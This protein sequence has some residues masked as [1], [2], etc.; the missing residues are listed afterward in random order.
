MNGVGKWISGVSL[1]AVL[2]A[3]A[4]DTSGLF[5]PD[6]FILPVAPEMP[7][8]VDILATNPSFDPDTGIV[9]YDGAFSLKADNG[10]GLK[11]NSA[12]YNS[13]TKAFTIKGNVRL[14][15][16]EGAK[17]EAQRV[18][19]DATTGLAKLNGAV[20][21]TQPARDGSYGIQLFS[22]RATLNT[23]EKTVRLTGDVSIYSGSTLH[24]GDSAFYD[25]SSR[26]FKTKNLRSGLD[27]IF[28]EAGAFESE[29]IDGRQVYVGENAGLTTHDRKD[30]NFWI[31]SN[32]T[33]VFPGEKVIFKN[34]KVYAGETPVF[35]LP[36]LSQ[37]LDKDLGYLFIPGARSNWG[38][39]LLNRYGIMLG[40][41]RDAVTG[42]NKDAWLLAQFHFDILSRRGIGL[43]VDLRDTRR[44][45]NEN[46]TGF[47][48]YYLNDSDPSQRRAGERRRNVNE[49]RYKIQ[50]RDKIRVAQML[51]SSRDISVDAF[52]NVTILSDEFYLE[53]FEPRTFRTD[54]EPDN[55]IG[56]SA[57]N[58]SSQLSLHARIQPNDFY[59]T[60]TRLPEITFDQVRRPIFEKRFGGGWLHE[61]HT[62]LGIFEEDLTG[63]RDGR[64]REE[65]ESLLLSRPGSPR[66]GEIDSLLNA[67]GFTRFHT[68][69]ELSRPFKIGKHLNIVPRAGIGYTAYTS[70]DGP[71]SSSDRTHLYAG[72]EAS[73]KFSKRYA[74]VSN[75]KLGLD[76]LLHIIQPYANAS[77]LRSDSLSPLF[78]GVD[79]LTPSTRP[80][81]RSPGRF[82]AIDDLEDWGV[83]RLGIRNRLLTSRDGGSHNWLSLDTYIDTFSQD[84]EFGRNISNLYNDLNWDPVP[85]MRLS[86]ETQFPIVKEESGFS[87]ISTSAT[88][89]P[90]RS[91]EFTVAHRFLKDNP[92]QEDSNLIDLR[93][94][95]RLSSLWGIE[96]RQRWEL[97]DGALEIQRYNLQRDFQSWIISAGLVIRDNRTVDEYGFLLSFILKD[98]PSVELPLS[99]D[100]D[101]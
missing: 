9:D 31:R 83:F 2:A 40:G 77:W 66:I 17:V 18:D 30:P 71:A 44:E 96:V 88:F 24:K 43:G 16:Q 19:Y 3:P 5:D 56:I 50:L 6:D 48:Y 12:S 22:N 35:W 1:A 42:E 90:A 100:T 89:M 69:Q 78:G 84:P 8:S 54:P 75:E 65:R 34:L 49:D 47:S 36:Y 63:V 45:D 80:R 25:Y 95:H 7:E 55:V 61:G 4:Q 32:K 20:S 41:E 68:Y 33:T 59:Q 97:E 93:V 11:G 76:G 99:I 72:V 15:T 98:F 74:N 67:R 53:D 21:I 94:Y 101:Q 37:P 52:A 27:P 13:K 73:L 85:W 26:K 87:E 82:S 86:L 57:Q 23:Q 46:L 38:A 39:F 91:T 81:L 14:T 29:T 10:V 79:T 58:Q 70:V 51:G 62:S 64:L 28:L 92:I 60:A